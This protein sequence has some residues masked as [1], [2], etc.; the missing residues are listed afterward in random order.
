MICL[1]G[2]HGDPHWVLKG[3]GS[4]E[5]PKERVEPPSRAMHKAGQQPGPPTDPMSQGNPLL[6]CTGPEPPL[7]LTLPLALSHLCRPARHL[8]ASLPL[9]RHSTHLLASHLWPKALLLPPGHVGL[10][11]GL[12]S[13]PVLTEHLPAEASAAATFH[14]ETSL[15]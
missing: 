13:F 12:P 8:P 10:F 1:D 6:S 4:A 9:H 7:P 11:L 5:T 3:F 2:K 14:S 15:C